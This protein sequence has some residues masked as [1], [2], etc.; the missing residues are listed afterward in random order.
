MASTLVTD[1]ATATRAQAAIA[2]TLEA[3][4]RLVNGFIIAITEEE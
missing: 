3:V 4:H 1:M 2:K